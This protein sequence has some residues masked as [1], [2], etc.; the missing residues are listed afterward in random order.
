V[1]LHRI[2]S[3]DDRAAPFAKT[4]KIHRKYESAEDYTELIADLIK[5]TGKARV[6][7]VARKMGITHVT[8][9]KTVQRLVRDGDVIKDGG[10]VL[11][12]KGE[13]MAMFCKKRHSTLSSFLRSLG[14]PEDVIAIDVEGIEHHISRVTLESIERHLYQSQ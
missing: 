6:C 13:E 2:L 11:T 1:I 12:E 7:D 4:R 3:M 9:L 8:V 10:L 5:D 14:V